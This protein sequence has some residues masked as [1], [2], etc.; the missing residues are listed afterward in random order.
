MKIN[1]KCKLFMRD[2]YLYDIVSC[3]YSI[4]EKAGF[5]VS[6]LEK[7]NKKKRNI[8]IGLLMKDNPRYTSLLRNTTNSIIDEYISINKLKDEEIVTRQYD[9]IIV[10]RPLYE[11]KLTIP[12]ALQSNIMIFISSLTRNSYISYDG[13]ITSIKGV[14]NKYKVIDSLYHQFLT[15]TNF[16]NKSSVFKQLQ[17]LK[18]LFLESTNT[19][20][21]CIPINDNSFVVYLKEF[22][23]IKIS[24]QTSKMLDIDD[25][26]KEWYFNFYIKPFAQSIV[27]EFA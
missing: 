6:F 20:L 26:D 2:I 27:L 22:G 11:T 14:P 17:K 21:F 13:K 10:T 19:N 9:G 4:L 8:Q 15:T 7:N 25:I 12:L 18:D 3:H 23:D 24:K 16:V 1:N 5:D